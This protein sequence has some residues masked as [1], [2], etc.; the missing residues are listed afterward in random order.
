M[1]RDP[2]SRSYCVR[3]R[4]GKTDGDSF[5][6]QTFDIN[7]GNPWIKGFGKTADEKVI[8][9]MNVANKS[10]GNRRLQSNGAFS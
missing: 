3:D 2:F 10:L 7:S 9:H 5:E 8:H 4:F 1:Q 6:R